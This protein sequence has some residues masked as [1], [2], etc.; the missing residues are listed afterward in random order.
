MSPVYFCSNTREALETKSATPTV[1]PLTMICV[2]TA[3]A[4]EGSAAPPRFDP[5][6]IPSKFSRLY[7]CRFMF[8]ALIRLYPVTRSLIMRR[9]AYAVKYAYHQ[10]GSNSSTGAEEEVQLTSCD[11]RTEKSWHAR[12]DASP[13]SIREW[14]VF[15][16]L[17]SDVALTA[18]Y[19]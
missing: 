15:S 14:T 11:M 4:H 6:V 13:S 17:K 10:G 19:C 7:T 3:D 2:R 8:E 16:V 18:S 9:L 5:K 12:Q 1:G